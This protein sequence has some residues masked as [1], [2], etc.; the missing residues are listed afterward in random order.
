MCETQTFTIRTSL[1]F[2]PLD[3]DESDQLDE[4]DLGTMFELENKIVVPT[5]DFDDDAFNKMIEHIETSTNTHIEM[6]GGGNDDETT[7]LAFEIADYVIDNVINA[8]SL[9][10]RVHSKLCD[11][12]NDSVIQES[13][14]VKE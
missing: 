6:I 2:Y 11:W 4:N 9:L 10:E 8:R 12:Y 14:D 7:M 5:R 13:G 1:I 3:L